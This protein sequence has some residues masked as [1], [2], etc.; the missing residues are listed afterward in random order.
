MTDPRFN[1]RSDSLFYLLGLICGRGYIFEKS[2]SVELPYQKPTVT[3]IKLNNN[4]FPTC[5]GNAKL[6][7]DSFC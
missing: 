7:L 6:E 3:W 1:K 2:L 4:D 5:A